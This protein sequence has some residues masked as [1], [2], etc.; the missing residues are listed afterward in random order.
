MI[1]NGTI[2]LVFHFKSKTFKSVCE[3]KKKS[4]KNV[5][6]KQNLIEYCQNTFFIEDLNDKQIIKFVNYRSKMW[7]HT[8][9][10]HIFF[11]SNN[12]FPA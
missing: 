7:V 9:E 1:T 3:S 10:P 6:W 11:G 12:S 2:K 5:K 4:K 8:V